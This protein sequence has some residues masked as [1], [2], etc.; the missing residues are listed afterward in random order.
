ME[1]KDRI[2]QA[3]KAAGLSQEQLG[4]KLGVSRQ[5]VSKWESGAANPDVAYLAAM[6]RELG[7]SSD[8]L[9]LG[10]EPDGAPPPPR[11]CPQCGGGVIERDSFCPHCGAPLVGEDR[12]DRYTLLLTVPG[13]Q[14]YLTY[15][16]VSGLSR[17]EWARQGAPWTGSIGSEKAADI[18]GRLPVVLCRGLTKAQVWE[19]MGLFQSAKVYPV[20]YRD[21]DG[22]TPEELRRAAPVPREDFRPPEEKGGM[23]FGMTVLAVIVGLIAAVL[24]LSIL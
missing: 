5:A 20:I 15:D 22:D 3:R 9:L 10:E 8:W 7:V 6:C 24:L 21:T 19:A 11:R 12:P 17:M 13:E 16:A 18:V 4:E 1:L 2:A 23:T 14:P